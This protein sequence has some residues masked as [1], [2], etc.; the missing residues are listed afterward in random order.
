[1]SADN[2]RA[3]SKTINRAKILKLLG[4]KCCIPGC[5]S[6]RDDLNIHHRWYNLG[7]GERPGSYASY[8]LVRND[9]DRFRLLCAAHHTTL[10]GLFIRSKIK[11]PYQTRQNEQKMFNLIIAD[12][13]D[14]GSGLLKRI[15]K[16]RRNNIGK[17]R[18]RQAR[19][20]N[21]DKINERRRQRYAEDIEKIRER[22]RQERA[23]DPEKF[24]ELCRNY[25][26]K[27]RDIINEHA[28]QRRAKDPEKFRERDRQRYA[29]G[30][31]EKHRERCRNYYA[32]NR[33]RIN[34]RR[35]QERAKDPEKFNER[36]RQRYAKNRDRINE[37]RRQ[38]RAEKRKEKK[39]GVNK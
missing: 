28:R 37:R 2:N 32:K 18:A 24:R 36:Q 35:R 27:N 15:E 1:M 3:E 34:E 19:A 11:Y 10:N 29:E 6:S 8:A 9:M 13:S 12:A 23:K 14:G 31:P 7:D 33:D 20:K 16:T 26:A 39:K 17:Q 25:Y 4:G 30:T 21:R 22:S 5:T 38:E